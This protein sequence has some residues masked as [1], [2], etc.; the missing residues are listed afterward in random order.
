[1]ITDLQKLMEEIMPNTTPT[2]SN[3]TGCK[4]EIP[5]LGVTREFDFGQFIELFDSTPDP[6]HPNI[7][8]IARVVIQPSSTLAADRN[9]VISN[10][11]FRSVAS[12]MVASQPQS[13]GDT[14]KTSVLGPRAFRPP[15]IT[16][17]REV[18]LF[19]LTEQGPGAKLAPIHIEIPDQRRFFNTGEITISD[20][21][22]KVP[23]DASMREAMTMGLA[24]NA[25]AVPMNETDSSISIPLTLTLPVEQIKLTNDSFTQ[26]LSGRSL[27]S[28]VG[29]IKPVLT[30]RAI[31]TLLADGVVLTHGVGST[32]QKIP[33]S[34]HPPESRLTPIAERY[35]VFDLPFFIA[36]PAVQATSGARLPVDLQPNNIEQLIE[37]R[38]TIVQMDGR[39][40]EINVFTDEKSP[41]FT[42]FL[43]ARE[44]LWEIDGNDDW[45]PAKPHDM[46]WKE[47]WDLVRKQPSK[48]DIVDLER[49]DDIMPKPTQSDG[50]GTGA[51][52]GASSMTD[53]V[54]PRLPS[55]TGLPVAVF[56]PWKQTWTLKGFS[57]GNLLHTIALAPLEQVT[58]QVF[59]WERRSR[60]LE[61]SSETEI[62]QQTELEQTTRDTEDV[63]REMIAK[64]DFAWQLSGSLDASYSNG[65]ASIQVNANGSVSDTTSIVATARNSSQHVSEST[66]KATSR[67]RSRRITRI[68]Q[69][70]ESGREERITRLIHNPNQC[71]TLTLDFFET[72]AHYEIQLEFVKQRMQLVVLVPNPIRYNDFSSE[73]IRRNET[74]LRNALIEPALLDGFESCRMVAAYDEARK[75]L[76]LQQSETTKLD[77]LKSQRDQPASTGVPDPAA[78]QQAEVERIV[79]EMIAALKTIRTNAE[80][81]SAMVAIRDRKPVSELVRS[82]GQK[83]LFI[84]FCASKFPALLATLDELAS[85]STAALTAAQKILAVLPKPDAPT[86]LGN[87]NQ[88]SDKD[89]EE[90]CIASKLREEKSGQRVY[91]VMEWDWAW[92]TGRLREE[93]LYN[94]NDAG[95]GGLAEQLQKAWQAWEAKKAQGAA[96]KDQEVTKTEAEGRQDKATS[97]DKLAMA[98]PLDELARAYERTKVLQDHF[99]EHREFYNY[100][101]FQALP[102][103]EQALRIVEASNGRLQVGLFEPR[104]VAMNGSRLVV[105][106]TPLAGSQ[107]LRDFV[108][109]L[110]ND[111]EQA[112]S[113]TLK[114]SDTAILPT[115]GMT[116][117]SRLG[118]CSSCEEYI[119]TARKHELARLE[120]LAHQEQR[121]ADRRQKRIDDN[122]YD[123]FRDPPA[124]FKLEVE[125]KGSQP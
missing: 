119:E 103:S 94:A 5:L 20:E 81:D 39:A 35:D 9:S 106:L 28:N 109:N 38:R 47:I 67:V 97:D 52:P 36:H 110:A 74:T 71:H 107:M 118:N 111:L 57:R 55:G 93:G 87:L 112:F 120:A 96:M 22:Y 45:I 91:M 14:Q 98:F 48:F 105:P 68:T 76:S 78:P 124:A 8:V 44:Q 15:N 30:P 70:I 7:P 2:A 54:Q 95:L 53:K 73:I 50:G 31:R 85:G 82:K 16:S 77:D 88:M 37:N 65:V 51:S 58:L 63:F 3:L 69:T 10:P 12:M 29:E 24:I 33:V 42:S 72:L 64:R 83:W 19:D 43:D 114:T 17:V 23:L 13:I 101:L 75:I 62:D 60:S 66:V 92:W 123:D 84:N 1:M 32:G 6:K 26:L 80:I 18:H 121:E 4:E 49:P 11:V 117:S 122:N 46:S 116:V 108:T 86:N 100:A 41:E 27:N 115:P 40:I 61:Q 21:T 79:N 125:N 104:V 25:F 99:N 59:S 90:S 113:Q 89:K 102:P 34:L 56:V